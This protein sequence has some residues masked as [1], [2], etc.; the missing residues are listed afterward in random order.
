MFD[1]L[2]EAI[3]LEVAF[4]LWLSE[5]WWQAEGR[6]AL[7]ADRVSRSLFVDAGPPDWF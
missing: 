2:L 3:R 1:A 5:A 7:S 4:Y 6:P